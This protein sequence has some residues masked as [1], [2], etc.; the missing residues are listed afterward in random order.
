MAQGL[1]PITPAASVAGV[2]IATLAAVAGQKSDSKFS[3]QK[4][5]TEEYKRYENQFNL[6][7]PGA[8]FRKNIVFYRSNGNDKFPPLRFLIN[9]EKLKQFAESLKLFSLE[10]DIRFQVQFY[11]GVKKFIKEGCEFHGKN[12][13]ETAEMIEFIPSLIS[14][15]DGNMWLDLFDRLAVDL[16]FDQMVQADKDKWKNIVLKILGKDSL[17]QLN[18]EAQRSS[19]I[20]YCL[21]VKASPQDDTSVTPLPRPGGM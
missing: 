1:K 20:Q 6:L 2:P 9:P 17:S 4:K 18:P 3:D 5:P 16:P 12:E 10:L 15:F 19:F 13:A 7:L 21:Q 8:K 11:E 14:D